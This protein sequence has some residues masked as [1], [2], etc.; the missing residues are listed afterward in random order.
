MGRK[1]LRQ[2]SKD[3]FTQKGKKKQPFTFHAQFNAYHSFYYK[4]FFIM[5]IDTQETL[6]SKVEVL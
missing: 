5:G 2:I 3:N 1:R 4:I 6:K